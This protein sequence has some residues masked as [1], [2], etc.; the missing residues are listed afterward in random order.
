MRCSRPRPRLRGRGGERRAHPRP[1]CGGWVFPGASRS[2]RGRGPRG[3]HAGGGEGRAVERHCRKPGWRHAPRVRRP[4]RGILRVQ[5][6][7]GSPSASSSSRD[8]STRAVIVDLDVHQGNGTAAIFAATSRSSP[9]PCTGARNYPFRKQRSSLDVDLAT[10]ARTPNT[11]RSSRFTC[12]AALDAARA[13]I[14]F[15]QGGVDPLAGDALGRLRP[16]ARRPA[17]AGPDG[18]HRRPR[19]AASPSC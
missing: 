1:R 13:D 12:R 19:P 10:A 2:S 8:G 4:R 9:F 15:Y 7:R 14:L 18:P 16:D 17:R 6:P 3:R 5:R 11:W